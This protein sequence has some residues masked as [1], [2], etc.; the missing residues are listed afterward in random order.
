THT[1]TTYIYPLSLHDALPISIGTVSGAPTSTTAPT[2]TVTNSAVSP[3]NVL[4]LKTNA[5][6]DT[7]TGTFGGFP[8]S[9]SDPTITIGNSANSNVVTLTLASGAVKAS[10]TFSFTTTESTGNF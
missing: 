7:A 6:T 1:P 4:T 10:R 8:V 2:I 9:T 3:S 5:T